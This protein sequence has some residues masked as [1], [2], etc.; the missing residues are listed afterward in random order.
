MKDLSAKERK[1]ALKW[2]DSHSKE[3]IETLELFTKVEF[4]QV[5]IQR[6]L[7]ERAINSKKPSKR[8]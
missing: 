6:F 2:I 8:G 5:L 3:E 4:A 1:E 7:K